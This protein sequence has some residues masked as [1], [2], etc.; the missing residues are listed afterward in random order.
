MGN[1]GSGSGSSYP[2]ALDT[3][4]SQEVNSPNALKTRAR[5][6][7][8]N[9]LASAV[10]AVETTLG[11][12]PH[13]TESNLKTYL[14]EE[15]NLD[16]T[17]KL[18]DGHSISAT[19][20][21]G[22]IPITGTD[23]T[24]SL[25][26]P[27]G[28]I[29]PFGGNTPPNGW[30]LCDGSAVSRSTYSALFAVIASKFGD[31]N[32]TTTFNLPNTARRV[33]M[34]SGGSGTSFTVTIASPAVFTSTSHGLIADWPIVFETTGALP[35]GLT[36]GTVYYVLSTGLTTDAFRVSASVGGAAVDTSGT[37]SGSHTWFRN[38]GS[39]V[40][41]TGGE[42]N[43]LSMWEESG[44]PSHSHSA[45]I[46]NL[47]DTGGGSNLR[48]PSIGNS[49]DTLMPVSVSSTTDTDASKSHNN[50]QPSLIVNWIIKY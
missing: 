10:I 18:I 11:T 43:H 35:T 12:N 17:H 37:Q 31:G 48:I 1:I 45:T 32:G 5:A 42:E 44:L 50:I 47:Y 21:N 41:R 8:P 36:A 6:E 33:L 40:G 13:G 38:I 9:D 24:L 7:V 15:H 16:G 39:G 28:V 34:G 20:G 30:L 4:T 29:W 2:T 27:T 46:S 49:N 23:S 3:Q 22:T 26:I 19:P 14:Q 25:F